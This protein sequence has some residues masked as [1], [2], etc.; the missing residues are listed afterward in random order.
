L[1]DKNKTVADAD[2]F[3]IA[4]AREVNWKVVTSETHSRNPDKPKI[5]D[6]CKYYG[7][8]CLNLQEFF[9]DLKFQI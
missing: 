2:A 3:V 7:T 4:L 9:E 6:V 5:P 1:V 8:P